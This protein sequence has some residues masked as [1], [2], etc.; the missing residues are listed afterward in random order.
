MIRTGHNNVTDLDTERGG[1][2]DRKVLVAPLVTV[3]LGNI[4]KVLPA[5]DHSAG[6][7]CRDNLAAQE[8]STDR[9]QTSPWALLVYNTALVSLPKF[10]LL[11]YHIP[12]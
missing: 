5:N 4:V 10:K 1:N 7:L 3:V 8:T 9:N 11:Q 12:M 2:V 6:H